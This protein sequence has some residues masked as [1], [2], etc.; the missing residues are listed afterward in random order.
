MIINYRCFFFS[1][2]GELSAENAASKR[3]IAELAAAESKRKIADLE[4]LLGNNDSFPLPLQDNLGP[5]SEL[6]HAAGGKAH[7]ELQ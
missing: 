7:P 4:R 5:L 1:F 6:I 2:S 3:I